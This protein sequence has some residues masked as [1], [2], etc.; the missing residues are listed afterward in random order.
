MRFANAGY[1]LR[2]GR[3]GYPDEGTRKAP[4]LDEQGVH[5]KAPK[6][7]RRDLNEPLS[8]ARRSA[9]NLLVDLTHGS[10]KV[11]LRGKNG[12]FAGDV[13]F[14]NGRS[15]QVGQSNFSF[16]SALI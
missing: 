1:F 10:G 5:I 4:L 16:A 11:R 15:L 7:P 12:S 13:I 9:R 2:T 14:G 8:R 6:T 3:G